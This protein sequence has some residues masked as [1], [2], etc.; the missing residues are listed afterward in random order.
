MLIGD[1]SFIHEDVMQPDDKR[2][3]HKKWGRPV[4]AWQSEVGRGEYEAAL[5]VCSSSRF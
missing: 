2:K 5:C 3:L 4:A 1:P